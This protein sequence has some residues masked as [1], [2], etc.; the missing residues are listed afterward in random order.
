MSDK[1]KLIPFGKYKDQPIEHIQ[2]IDR[3]Y[4][5]WLLKQPWFRDK[6][7]QQYQIVINYGGEPGET[8]EHNRLQARLL[9]HAFCIALAKI[10]VPDWRQTLQEQW[11]GRVWDRGY[12]G[13]GYGSLYRLQQAN[14]KLKSCEDELSK[15]QKWI[16]D[17]TRSQHY[18]DK[19]S[20]LPA[21][22]KELRAEI[23]REEADQA[24]LAANIETVPTKWS[25]TRTEFEVAGWDAVIA[26][27]AALVGKFDEHIHESIG[28]EAKPT[29]GDDYPAVLRQI[30]NHGGD[31][32]RYRVLLVEQ[33]IASGATADEIEKIFVGSNIKLVMVSSVEAILKVAP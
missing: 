32:V 23:A 15:L 3:Q 16:D 9:D 11:L 18:R 28:I 25:V 31:H 17:S 26:V 19:L 1:D 22:I 8:P 2:T 24:E 10:V 7:P 14:W 20:A 30:K 33:V 5:E 13:G 4:L 12:Y 27:G 29:L 21:Q 6:F